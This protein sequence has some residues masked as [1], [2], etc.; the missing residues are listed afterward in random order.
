VRTALLRAGLALGST[1][2]SLGAAEV[3]LRWADGGA[4]PQIRLYVEDGGTLT[5]RA[6]AS[7]EAVLARRHRY[8][9]H[10]SAHGVRAAAPGAHV[11]PGAWLAV[12]DS[13][14]LG[15]GVPY[16]H[17]F[18]ALA[19]VPMV[20]AGVPSYGLDDALA[21]AEQLVPALDARGVVVV[22]NQANDW[23][24]IG[25]RIEAR[26][27]VAG[28]WLLPR[29]RTSDWQRR[30]YGSSWSGLH[31]L[32]HPVSLVSGLGGSHQ[33]PVWL[34]DPEETSRRTTRLAA[35]LRA[36][37]PGVP[38]VVAYLPLDVFVA[39]ARVA[40]S[41]FGRVLDGYRAWE[42]TRMADELAAQIDVVDL[43]GA[44]RA[45]GAFLDGD[46]HLSRDGH[47]RVAEALT[48]ALSSSGRAPTR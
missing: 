21:R 15:L 48:R 31:L 40:R 41:P 13:Q 17:T 4:L 19:G 37:D 34:R 11:P 35:Q 24:E 36:F 43:S 10:T 39:E 7:S 22:L 27:E 16:E 3:A 32:Y 44:L 26:F 46:Y 2:V 1:V 5:L 38:V 47:A 8:L 25:T 12:G 18:S 42:D 28:G 29:G 14:V 30:F 9:V 45:P 20:S 6:D 33:A 23:D